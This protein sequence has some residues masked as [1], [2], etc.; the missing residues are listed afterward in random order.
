MKLQLSVGTEVCF[1]F[2]CFA[3]LRCVAA[4]E[5]SCF[6]RV[7]L[8]EIIRTVLKNTPETQKG[9]ALKK[10]IQLMTCRFPLASTF[11]LLFKVFGARSHFW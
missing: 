9:G 1:A 5:D 6:S 10:I 11:D 3:T 8:S 7:E 4:E 2:C